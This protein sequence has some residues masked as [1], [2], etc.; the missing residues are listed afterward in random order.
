MPSKPEKFGIKKFLTKTWRRLY[1]DVHLELAHIWVKI[2]CSDNDDTISG[3]R[4]F[5]RLSNRTQDCAGPHCSPK[6]TSYSKEKLKLHESRFF[7]KRT[8]NW[9]P[10]NR[11]KKKQFY[12]SQDKCVQTLPTAKSLPEIIEYYNHN[13][14]GVDVVD[15]MLK[16]FSVKTPSRRCPVHVFY[17]LIDTALLN[18]YKLYKL[19]KESNK[20]LVFNEA[21]S[22]VDWIH[23]GRG[24]GTAGRCSKAAGSKIGIE[25]MLRAESSLQG[26]QDR[27]KMRFM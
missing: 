25:K 1:L 4:E 9:R 26:Q 10:T 13:K 22:R 12:S 7:T 24:R 15:K 5:G 23:S 18:A 21:S 6:Q 27:W 3:A 11:R 19:Y 8:A 16:A 14:I 20:T 17:N 2:R